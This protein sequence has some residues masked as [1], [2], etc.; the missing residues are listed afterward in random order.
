M[1][2]RLGAIFTLVLLATMGCGGAPKAAAANDVDVTRV[3]A[4]QSRNRDWDVQ[5]SEGRLVATSRW[6]SCLREDIRPEVEPFLR[7]NAAE[8]GLREPGMNLAANEPTL[9]R[10][11]PARDKGKRTVEARL[12]GCAIVVTSRAPRR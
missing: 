8:L 6:S 1:L 5:L 7:S 10:Y 2:I 9:V 12:S 3:E 11:E 4:F